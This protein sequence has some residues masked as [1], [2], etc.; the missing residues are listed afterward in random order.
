MSQL[1]CHPQHCP[2]VLLVTGQ[3]ENYNM[4]VGG[5]PRPSGP[6]PSVAEGRVGPDAQCVK[7]LCKG[8]TARHLQNPD[9]NLL[10][11]FF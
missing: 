10:P 1:L 5:A 11:H 8:H 9:E 6:S 3:R 7:T 2:P 4:G